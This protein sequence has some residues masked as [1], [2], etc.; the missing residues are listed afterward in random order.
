LSGQRG[1]EDNG[2]NRDDHRKTI[3]DS[4]MSHDGRPRGRSD[5][6]QYCLTS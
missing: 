2:Q 1:D 4:E 5:R 6:R 3:V